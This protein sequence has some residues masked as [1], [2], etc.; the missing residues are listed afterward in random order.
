MLFTGLIRSGA[1][2]SFS[3]RRGR[4]L[5]R[6]DEVFVVLS[7]ITLPCRDM[8]HCLA[9]LQLFTFRVQGIVVFFHFQYFLASQDDK[10]LI[11]WKTQYL[12]RSKSFRLPTELVSLYPGVVRYTLGIQLLCLAVD[13]DTDFSERSEIKRAVSS[14]VQP[15]T[16]GYRSSR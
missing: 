10:S 4:W 2:L 3:G 11:Q 8:L 7:G 16:A 15:K 13:R 14:S 1:F 12:I 5:Q 9:G 6:T